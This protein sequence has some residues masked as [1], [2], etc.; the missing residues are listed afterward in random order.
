MLSVNIINH[1]GANQSGST[2][3]E[4]QWKIWFSIVIN[5]SCSYVFS[6]ARVISYEMVLN[7]YPFY[8]GS[9]EIVFG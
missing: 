4:G 6:D 9:A 8:N 2:T 7:L 1:H 3:F 5:T